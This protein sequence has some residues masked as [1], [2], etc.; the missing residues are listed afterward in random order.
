MITFYQCSKLK[1]K[2]FWVSDTISPDKRSQM[3]W[4]EYYYDPS[5]HRLRGT[6]CHL[7]HCNHMQCGAL[8]HTVAWL[9]EQH[10]APCFIKHP[11]DGIHINLD[12]HT[13]IIFATNESSTKVSCLVK[14]FLGQIYYFFII[15][16]N[17]SC[18]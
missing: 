5:H 12:L 9:P 2:E 3:G 7:I 4:T 16:S 17:K 10:P 11:K 18:P 15:F 6:V 8:Q 1:R 14:K 13:N